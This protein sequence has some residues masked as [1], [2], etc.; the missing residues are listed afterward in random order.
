M[1]T[2]INI[3]CLCALQLQIGAERLTL[4]ADDKLLTERRSIRTWQKED[5]SEA[6]CPDCAVGGNKEFNIPIAL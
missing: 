6:S 3:F 1:L 4:N 2:C 5:R